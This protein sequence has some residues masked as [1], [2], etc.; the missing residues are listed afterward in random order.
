MELW[1]NFP[2]NHGSGNPSNSV[3]C[4][5]HIY[6]LVGDPGLSVRTQLPDTLYAEIPGDI[7]LGNNF[8]PVYI[9]DQNDDA[10]EGAFVN[11]WKGDE[12]YIRSRFS[13]TQDLLRVMGKGR[14]NR[15]INFARTALLPATADMQ[16]KDFL[17]KANTIHN[18]GDDAAP[19]NLNGTYIGGNHG[20]YGVMEITSA[21]HG[22]KA[23]DIGS[24]VNA[25]KT[26]PRIIPRDGE[27]IIHADCKDI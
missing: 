7:P 8:Y 15:Q 9:Y 25:V 18:C 16:A 10:V 4:Y 22:L 3:D 24:A 17:R 12:V 20:S 19:W 6:N 1:N 26:Q 23:A 27:V 14:N 11:L 5:Y 13:D 2:Y 21:G